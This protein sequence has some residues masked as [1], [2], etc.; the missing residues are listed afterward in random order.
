MGATITLGRLHLSITLRIE[1][2]SDSRRAPASWTH[3]GCAIPHRS[4]AV[5]D[6]CF[7]RRSTALE[8]TPASVSLGRRGEV[9]IGERVPLLLP[10]LR[11][12]KAE[13]GDDYPVFAQAAELIVET[14]FGSI[15][16]LQRKLR[17][18]F[19]RATEIAD[20]LER[21]GIVGPAQGSGPRDV[22]IAPLAA[23]ERP[24]ETSRQADETVPT[25]TH[26]LSA[27]SE[28]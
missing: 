18:G 10:V 11:K 26:A 4:R 19:A 20:Q 22:L 15:S 7:T 21:Y 12:A 25:S 8:S 1:R 16:M 5:A 28:A 24:W 2:R 23:G 6:Q 3:P 17:I 9:L 14:Q 27:S 13:L